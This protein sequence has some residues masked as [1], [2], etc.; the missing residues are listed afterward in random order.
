MTD[1]TI[2]VRITAADATT[3][4]LVPVDDLREC[5]R[6]AEGNGFYGLVGLFLVAFGIGGRPYA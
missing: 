4:H 6:C 2:R 5:R 1:N 3:L